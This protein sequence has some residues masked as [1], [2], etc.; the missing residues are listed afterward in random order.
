MKIIEIIELLKA[1]PEST[2][3][4]LGE[5]EIIKILD[6]LSD[7]YYNH[8]PI[9]SDELFDIIKDFFEKQFDK[10]YEKVGAPVKANNIKEKNEKN[11]NNENLG[12]QGNIVKLPYWLGSLD[13][14]KPSSNAFNN[15]IDKFHGPYV[16]S[17][18]L[19]GISALL[20]KSNKQVYMYTRGN[21]YDGKD[22]SHCIDLI[23]INISKMIE[24][25]A[26]R[27]ELIISREN[28]KK[29]S[30]KMA[31]P[32][33][34]VAGIIGTKKKP[35]P[36]L[37]KLI[38][39]VAYWVL[40]PQL[41]ASD[42]LEYIKKKEFVP[43]SVEYEIVNKTTL[44][45]LSKK[46]IEG[47]NTH[48]YEIDGLVV[49]DNSMYYPLESG[50]N[51]SYG[52]AFKQLLTDQIAE[53]TIIDV[54]WEVSKDKYIKPKIQINTIELGGVEISFATAFNA[55]FVVD[56]CIGPGALIQIVR[57]GD[58]IPKIEKVIKPAETGKPKMP[59][60]KYVWNESGVD[61]IAS[62]LDNDTMKKIIIKKLTYFFEKLGIKWMGE[63]TVEKFVSNGYD[64]LWKILQANK[65][66]IEDIDGFGKT[67][68][69]KLYTSIEDGLKERKL[70]EIMAASQVF[71]RGIGT[72]KFKLIT[73]NYP[74]ILEIYKEKGSTHTKEL[75]NN[76]MGFNT[77]TTNKI[78]D[79]MGEFIIYLN[80]FLKIKPNLL[81]SPNN[82]KTIRYTKSTKLNKPDEPDEPDEPDKPD[83]QDEPDKPDKP[84]KQD[85]LD[86][87]DNLINSNNLDKFANKKIVFTGFRDK[88][89]E[90]ELENI[91]SKIS[92]S[93]SKNT[94]LVIAANI[95]DKSSKIIKAKELKIKIISKEEFYK[96]IKNN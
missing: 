24:G 69:S 77:K 80:K 91:G 72:K 60:I 6:Y 54:L 14:I 68:I 46:L 30:D 90:D 38:D 52:F 74:N 10:K 83:K 78:V 12:N 73:N 55:K 32:R 31:N 29:I 34:A 27:G 36:K 9:I 84:D 70:E 65:K 89:I 18:K 82:I 67:I 48:K 8:I 17:W 23:G 66:Q 64:D 1:D 87:L 63:T 58:V 15:W 44:N 42:Q 4:S 49:L 5:K 11:E 57:S 41:K 62:E 94:D 79:L 2:L 56:N 50:S 22:I 39:F 92:S 86:N 13:K 45:E 20:Y 81:K 19:D 61:I 75:I 40:S 25:D 28:F 76:I 53:A 16:L 21:G 33:N 71:G 26:I 37:Y 95:N 3:E 35:D 7:K 96:I 51:P 85:E 59:K 88:E 93:V 47:R 43:R